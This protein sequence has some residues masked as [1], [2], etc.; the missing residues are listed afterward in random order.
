MPTPVHAFLSNSE[1][2]ILDAWKKESLWNT[3]RS[4]NCSNYY[5]NECAGLE[6]KETNNFYTILGIHLK[7]G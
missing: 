3:G 6:N 7:D 2:L 1:N 5:G 4:I